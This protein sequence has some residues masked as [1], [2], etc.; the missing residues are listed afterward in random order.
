[1][2][3]TA[4][5][6]VIRGTHDTESLEPDARGLFDRLQSATIR[7]LVTIGNAS[8]FIVFETTARQ[9][10]RTVRAFLDE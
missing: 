5:T 6:L 1:S 8:H 2:K 3:I 7:R 4:P 9:V 10:H